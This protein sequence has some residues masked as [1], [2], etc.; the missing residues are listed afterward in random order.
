MTTTT[1]R[2]LQANPLCCFCGGTE[3]SVN[4]DHQPARVMIPDKH[5][6]KGMEF[7]SCAICN[8]QTS[9][10]V[11][12]MAF[13]ARV[14]GN[15]RFKGGRLDKGFDKAIRAVGIALPFLLPQIVGRTWVPENGVLILR[16]TFNGNHAQVVKSA[17]FVAAKLGL[18]AYYE[19][20]G[21]SAP[22]T[23][24]IKTMWT[25]YQN[26]SLAVDNILRTM[27]GQ[28]HLKQGRKWD[29]QD[30]FFRRIKQH[31]PAAPEPVVE[32]PA[33]RKGRGERPAA[34]RPA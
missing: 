27:P 2:L 15:H 8:K 11:A 1:Q 6:P 20:H 17:C 23:V 26:T 31:Q 34:S 10:D 25:H 3:K 19:H 9:Q 30:T 13:F 29:T 24:K 14:T 33:T 16:L 4:L 21:K 22:S 5:R 32:Q 7:P 12:L 28:K 18:A